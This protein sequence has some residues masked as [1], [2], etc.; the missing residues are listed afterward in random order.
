MVETGL[1]KHWCRLC[2]SVNMLSAKLNEIHYPKVANS[3]KEGLFY[4]NK[5]TCRAGLKLGNTAAH[6]HYH[7]LWWITSSHWTNVI[8]CNAKMA[9]VVPDS[10]KTMS[11]GENSSKSTSEENLSQV[12]PCR[13][14]QLQLTTQIHTLMAHVT[15][16]KS[17]TIYDWLRTIRSTLG[18]ES[19]I[20]G[21]QATQR[22]NPWTIK[23]MGR[24]KWLLG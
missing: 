24:A 17:K 7:G 14:R 16:K 5:S 15:C 11:K 19:N 6:Q 10:D 18:E 8:L 12:S 1:S 23:Q 3:I 13:S 22:G 20:P 21:H 2:I 9:T 4:Q